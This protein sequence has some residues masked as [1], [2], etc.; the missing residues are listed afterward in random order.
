MKIEI[1]SSLP[2]LLVDDELPALLTHEVML[3]SFGL[4][5]IV[6][7]DDSTKVMEYL[8]TREP[9]MIFLD[10]DMPKL[11][12]TVL[13]KQL[14]ENYPEIPVVIVTGANSVE[15]AVDCMKVGA[16]DYLVKPVEEDRISNVARR[17][18]EMRE[19]AWVSNTFNDKLFSGNLEFP[20]SFSEII[21]RNKT[22]FTIFQY[23]ES[24]APTSQ[25]VLI[26]GETGVGKELVARA[27]HKASKRAGKFLGENVAGL[28]DNVISDTLFGHVKG[29]FTGADKP[30]DGL[31]EKAAH[32]TLLLDEIGEIGVSTQLKLLRL[33]QEREYFPVGSD[34]SKVSSV[35]VITSTNREIA[36]LKADKNFRN[37]LFYRLKTHHIHIPPLRNRKEDIP[38]LLDFFM[39]QA[40]EE[41]GK[42]KPTAPPELITLLATYSFP[43]NIREFRAL[44]FDAVSKHKSRMLSMDS[45]KASMDVGGTS[46]VLDESAGNFYSSMQDLPT[47]KESTSLLIEEAMDRAK[48]NQS[49]AARILGITPSSLSKR[50]K[51]S[52][53]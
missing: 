52:E 28:D 8:T 53:E 13:L 43:G 19:M 42:D 45:F 47:I 1:G 33:L 27:I 34:I 44:A 36:E 24:I 16:F 14:A 49:A 3:N 31:V 2:V 21:T 38:L 22:M 51:R 25:P 41:L 48:G 23:I 15:K 6:K 46:I 7:I 18:L 17:A 30:R 20:D 11:H 26:T 12:G 40:A 37:D 35:R 9:G 4:D 5:N 29:A 39:E 50:I 10:L 32:G